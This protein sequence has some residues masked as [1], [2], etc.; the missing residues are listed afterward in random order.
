MA[1][2]ASNALAFAYL[3]DLQL[4][5]LAT[6]VLLALLLFAL[7]LRPSLLITSA[8]SSSSLMLVA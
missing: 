3:T 8:L 7:G 4:N 5:E 6:A 2:G 1:L